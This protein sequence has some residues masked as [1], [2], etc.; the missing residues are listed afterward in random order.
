MSWVNTILDIGIIGMQESQRRKLEQL[1]QE[2]ANAEYLQTVIEFLRN[3]VYKYREAAREILAIEAQAPKVSAAAMIILD[4][5]L[6]ALNLTPEMF[7]NLSDKEYVSSTIRGI[8]SESRR[9]LQKMDLSQ[10]KEVAGVVKAAISLPDIIFYTDNFESVKSFDKAFAIYQNLKGRN[11]GCLK[12]IVFLGLLMIIP[13]LMALTFAL[14]SSTSLYDS[15]FILGYCIG[16][17]PV[18]VVFYFFNKVVA[19]AYDYKAAKSQVEDFEKL[20]IDLERFEALEKKF[21]LSYGRL[22]AMRNELT[23][24]VEIFFTD[25]DLPGVLS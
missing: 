23:K 16:I 21:N 14:I 3:E 25:H 8:R 10:K 18:L 4:A 11:G 22:V 7:P 20:E 12:S 1:Q 5:R 6:Q 17:I 19:R 24:Q 2:N 15:T 9:L 13:S